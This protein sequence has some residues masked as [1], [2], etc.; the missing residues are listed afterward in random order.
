MLLKNLLKNIEYSCEHNIDNLDISDI[1]FDSRKANK[2]TVFVCLKGSKVD[3]HEFYK[4]AIKN[5][6]VAIVA[7]DQLPNVNVPIVYVKNTREALAYMSCEFFD[8]PAEKLKTIGITGTKGKT[9]TSCMVRAI[10]KEAGIK[11]G[12]IGTLGVSFDAETIKTDNT[13]PESYDIQKYL[14]LMVRKNCKVAIMEVSSI[15]LKAN[16]VDGITFDYGIFT[17]FSSDHIGGDEHKDLDEYLS[18]KSMLFKKCKIGILN[19]DDEHYSNIL[20][21]HTCKVRS[22]GFSTSADLYVE[23][24]DLISDKGFLGTKFKVTGCFEVNVALNIPGKFNIYNALSAISVCSYF[25]ISEDTVNNAFKNLDVKG[26]IECVDVPGNYTLIID[27][28]HNALSMENVLNTLRE[29]KPK[30]LIVLFG[31][32]GNRPKIRRYEMGEVAGR[33]A[34]LSI[35]TEDNSRYENVLDIISDIEVGL[36]KSSGN[37]IV[38]PDRR[39]AIKYCILAARAGDIIV[40][41]GKGHE[42]YQEING[43]K[44]NFDERDVISD[45]LKSFSQD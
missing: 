8:N 25:E 34:D 23:N 4:S 26:R 29:Y 40:L 15:G 35:V 16:R 17:N 12:V 36:K 13:T 14:N 24:F 41:A 11:A 44:Y 9:T 7:Q 43:V 28:A 1:V 18:C 19:M 33:L 6:A 21:G 3:G 5:G 30:R 42:A 2:N 39:E 32:G 20:K 45:I 22:Y 31:A 38:I 37:Y 27:Y 10:L